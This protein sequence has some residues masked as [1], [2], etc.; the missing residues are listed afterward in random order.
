MAD[1]DLDFLF[2]LLGVRQFLPD[3]TWLQ[4]LAPQL[5]AELG[6]ACED[7]LFWIA[8]I[9]N[10]LNETR[11]PVSYNLRVENLIELGVHL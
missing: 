10:H 4:R 8:G 3:S 7:M 2:Q 6:W 1:L 9:T 5:C 11:I